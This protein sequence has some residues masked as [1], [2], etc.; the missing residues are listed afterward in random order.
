MMHV[1]TACVAVAIVTS[2]VLLSA[3]D[4]PQWRG[5]LNT[6]AS[7]DAR[8]PLTWS[9]TDNI[10]WKTRLGGV[11]VSSPVVVGGRVFVTSQIGVGNSATGPRLGQGADAS[12]TERSLSNTGA[13]GETIRFLVEAFDRTNGR[14]LWTHELNAEGSAPR[15]H[16]KHNLSSS[17][18]ATDGQRVYAMFGT[19]QII[20]LD[21]SGKPIWTRNLARDFGAFDINWGYSSSPV[22]YRN[23]VILVCYQPSASYVIA[24][25]T[26]TGKQVW[27]VDRPSGVLSY[28]TPL[29]VPAAKGD[30]LVVNSSVGVEALNPANGE[31]LWRFNEPNNFPIPV[32]L[33]A[34]DVIFF[35]RGYRSGPYGAIRPGLRGDV[36]ESQ[37]AWHVGTGAPYISSFVYYEGLLYMAGDV[38]VI[39]CIDAKTGER[40]WRHRLD[41]VFTASP[42][43]GD[44]KIYVLSEAGETTVFKAGRQ[45]EVL[46]KNAINGRV[47]ASPAISGGRLFLRT[48]DAL[49]A[50]GAA[51]A[52]RP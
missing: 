37:L 18:P 28:S 8:L 16:D 30:E 22:V 42:V 32:A 50:V 15:T 25:D 4:W 43:A 19:G 17:S 2:G 36:A 23:T 46:A 29:I 26:A 6:G 11:G 35:S 13:S 3:A 1:R 20:A 49:V 9:D 51:S 27:K 47:L 44:G 14:R 39:T 41:G 31:S 34:D 48:D 12:P 38:G 40:V 5:H 24:L 33:F 10:A 52:V 21:M 7:A 45:V